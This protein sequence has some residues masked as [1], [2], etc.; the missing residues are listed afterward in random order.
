MLLSIF[1]G[2]KGDSVWGWKALHTDLIQLYHKCCIA[3]SFHAWCTW[4]AILN[5]RMAPEN[6]MVLLVLL[7]L[8]ILGRLDTQ[9]LVIYNMYNAGP[10]IIYG[11]LR[12]FAI[13]CLINMNKTWIC[14]CHIWINLYQITPSKNKKITI[15]IDHNLLALSSYCL[16][17]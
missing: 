1:Y 13:H 5:W 10:Q 11:H 6:G 7:E 14:K 8:P 17:P 9:L 15:I 4:Y 2:A 3:L 12:C 16:W